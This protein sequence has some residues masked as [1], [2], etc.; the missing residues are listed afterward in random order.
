VEH[1]RY[2]SSGQG[3]LQP[4][5]AGLE[6]DSW[7]VYASRR[8]IMAAVRDGYDVSSSMIG[9]QYA[10]NTGCYFLFISKKKPQFT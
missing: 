2:P 4:V 5:S 8:L 9:L 1:R 7:A 3:D 6:C 10:V